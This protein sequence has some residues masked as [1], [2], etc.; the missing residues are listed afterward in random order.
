VTN[1]LTLPDGPEVVTECRECPWSAS[2]GEPM[3]KCAQAEQAAAEER[4]QETRD[5]AMAA[6]R[7][8]WACS[9][10]GTVYSEDR[11]APPRLNRCT[12]DRQGRIKLMTQKDV[13]EAQAKG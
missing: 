11:K 1:A 2:T 7:Q 8:V 4:F 6:Q 13:E 12:C 10:C 9:V 3:C 5:Q